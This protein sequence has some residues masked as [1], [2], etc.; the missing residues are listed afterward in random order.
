MN[1]FIKNML[2]TYLCIMSLVTDMYPSMLCTLE[3]SKI[4]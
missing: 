1:G 4:K 2:R 3:K